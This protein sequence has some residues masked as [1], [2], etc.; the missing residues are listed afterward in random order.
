VP[1]HDKEI[2]LLKT[3]NLSRGGESIDVT[4]IASP[5]LKE[6]AVAAAQACQLGIAGVDIITE[7]IENGST[8][9]SFIIEV[10]ASPG[11]RMHHFPSIGQPRNVAAMIFDELE[12]D[13]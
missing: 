9:D 4:D 10:N 6:M 3:S 12:K 5:K 13:A 7:D 2:G 8:K 11:L 1:D